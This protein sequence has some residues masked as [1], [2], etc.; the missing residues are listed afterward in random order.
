[1]TVTQ[2]CDGQQC[3]MSLRHVNGADMTASNEARARFYKTERALLQRVFGSSE[4]ALFS[5]LHLEYPQWNRLRISPSRS[6]IDVIIE[7]FYP[8]KF[9]NHLTG[10]S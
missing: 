8:V 5:R 10:V 6:P 7:N 9:E 1:M 4:A 2:V 3:E